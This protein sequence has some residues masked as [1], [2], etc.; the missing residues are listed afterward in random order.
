[1]LTKYTLFTS[2][3]ENL[4]PPDAALSTDCAKPINPPPPTA[5]PAVFASS[6]RIP[7]MS[8]CRKALPIDNV[9][10]IKG[11]FDDSRKTYRLYTQNLGCLP[12]RKHM[13]QQE[14]R[15]VELL[16]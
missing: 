7:S 8:P 6:L 12:L 4:A 16:V 13:F 1:M 11:C 14:A 15:R 10:I 9:I 5:C 2:S 3:F